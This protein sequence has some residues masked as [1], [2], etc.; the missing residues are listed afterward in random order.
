VTRIIEWLLER[1]PVVVFVIVAIVQIARA[2]MKSREAQAGHEQEFDETEEQ[3]RVREIQERLRRTIAARRGQPEE[4]PSPG[5]GPA[6]EVSLPPVLRSEPAPP[7][8]RSFNRRQET[9]ER[10]TAA[11]WTA[12]VAE[13]RNTELDR[14]AELAE[15]MSRLAEA[16]ESAK[17]RAAHLAKAAQE[18][19]S[20]GVA[21]ATGPR[22]RLQEDLR[23]PESLRRAIV[24][25]EILGT[26]VGLR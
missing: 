1:L 11:P 19:A 7:E 20:A 14:Q 24:L 10:E 5:T 21:R 22:A 2:V 9:F 26:P 13:T 4:V 23:Q 6:E 17:R 3:R 8:D 25:R 12:P 15:Q 18:Q 16:R